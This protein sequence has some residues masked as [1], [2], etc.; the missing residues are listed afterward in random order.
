MNQPILHHSQSWIV[1]TYVSFVAALAMIVGGI[2]LTPIDLA[3][4]DYLAM[5]VIMLIQSCIT[6]T[7][8]IRDNDEAGKLRIPA[9]GRQ[10][11]AP[12]D[13]RRQRPALN[14]GVLRTGFRHPRESGD[15]WPPPEPC[16]PGF[17][18]FA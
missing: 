2:A 10:D 6:L 7:K 17:P 5:G 14:S 18:L 16:C 8:T 12:V 1:F 11:R 13:G 15:P 3:M 4:K 9:R